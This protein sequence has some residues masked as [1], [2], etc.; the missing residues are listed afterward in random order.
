V[1]KAI[2]DSLKESELSVSPRR[3]FHLRIP[4]RLFGDAFAGRSGYLCGL[5]PSVASWSLAIIGLA[6]IFGSLL[7]GFVRLQV[8]QQTRLGGHVRLARTC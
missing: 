5:P 4:H 1:L 7:R 2:G 8:P 6:N 3:L